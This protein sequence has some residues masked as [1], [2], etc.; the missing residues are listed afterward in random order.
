M[1]SVRVP[2]SG[3][4]LIENEFGA[5]ALSELAEP[6]RISTPVPSLIVAAYPLV[7]DGEPGTKFTV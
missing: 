2:F 4:A 6:P 7:G 1:A 5:V 3:A